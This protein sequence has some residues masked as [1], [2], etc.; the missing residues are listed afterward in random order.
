MKTAI[1]LLN[2]NGQ[3]LLE[4]FLPDLLLHAQSLA[5]V[6][7]VDNA[8][9]DGSVDF[10]KTNFPEIHLIQHQ[11]N[12]GYADGYNRAVGQ[13]DADLL[14]LINNDVLTTAGWLEPMIAAFKSKPLLAMAQ[15]KI[16][17]LNRPTH[18]E[19][20]GAA[21]G[22][23]DRFGYPF[24]RGRIFDHVEEDRNQYATA[25][26][27]WASG[28]C[29]FVRK[30]VFESLK[31]FDGSFFAHME[32]IDLCWRA[33]LLGHQVWAIME[34]QVFHLGGGTLT[35]NSPRKTRLNF[36]N[37]LFM[38][39]KNTQKHLFPTLLVRMILDG[40]AA[41]RFMFQGKP[42]HFAA[43][44]MA[45]IDLYRKG[46]YYRGHQS[47]ALRMIA[48]NPSIVWKYYLLGRKTY[49]EL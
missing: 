6:Y 1:V 18:F 38:L 47:K 5:S 8:S 14:C 4:R 40:L 35:Y 45:H 16:L 30:N 49:D 9:T 17:N 37:S 12:L 42:K 48:L 29:L 41:W 46:K 22:F 31:G 39:I 36:R 13:I 25:E 26:I 32:E 11:S 21:G 2:W 3:A 28:A 23:L 34:S 27:F 33:K 43:I 15:P 10:I 24:C 7:V 20:A 44:F 19:Y